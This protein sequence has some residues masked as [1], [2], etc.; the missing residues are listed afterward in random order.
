LF[1][2][3]DFS[4]D[5]GWYYQSA[6]VLILPSLKEG[7]PNVVLEAMACGLPCVAARASGSRELII[8]GETGFT[9]AHGNVEEMGD[10]VRRCLS[11]ESVRMGENAREMAQTHYSIQAITNRYEALYDQLL[12]QTRGQIC[13]P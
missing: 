13:V 1:A 9:Y 4:S 7:L 12:S 2:L 3:R 6:D 11:P 8:E 10:A 5:I